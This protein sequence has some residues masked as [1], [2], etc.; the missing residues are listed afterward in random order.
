MAEGIERLADVAGHFA[1]KMRRQQPFERGQCAILVLAGDTADMIE[2]D[3]AAE[4]G[5]G[6]REL[7]GIGVKSRQAC[8][9]RSLNGLR[10]RSRSQP[11]GGTQPQCARL[12]KRTDGFDR[13]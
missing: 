8:A 3:V 2:V 13:E 11:G 7:V 9:D 10:Q 12:Q 4:H 1:Q 6:A 5:R